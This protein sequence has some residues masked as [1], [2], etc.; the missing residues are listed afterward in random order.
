MFVSL[1]VC[2]G[3]FNLSYSLKKF[4]IYFI[5]YDFDRIMSSFD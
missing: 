4:R 1:F 5:A 3:V 2:F